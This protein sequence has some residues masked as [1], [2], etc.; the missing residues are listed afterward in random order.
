MGPALPPTGI[1]G[2]ALTPFTEDNGVDQERLDRLLDVMVG[3]CDAISLLGAEVSEYQILSATDRLATLR[4]AIDTV[5]RRV[6]V[7]AGASHPDVAEVLRLAEYA[8]DAG[9]D[10]IQVLMPRH[11][12][13]NPASVGDL[14]AY[15]ERIAAASPLPII[16]YHNPSQGTDTDAGTMVELA[17]LDGVVGFKESSRDLI[18]IGRLCAEIDSAG[19]ARYYTTMQA[20]LSTLLLGG[21]GAMMPP[22]GTAIGARVVAAH[23]EGDH[24]L[25]AEWQRH[26]RQFPSGWG[27]YGLTTTMKAAMAALGHDVG[28]PAAPFRPMPDADADRLAHHLSSLDLDSLLPVSTGTGRSSKGSA[29]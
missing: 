6:P 5:G 17:H 29:S 21:S 27:K 11:P 8:A 26:F 13:G 24:P 4:A 14:I 1:I 23:R 18:K 10:F 16:A 12:G 3:H 9:A 7:L 22:P 28:G 2:A 25:A 20:L 19:E 15:F